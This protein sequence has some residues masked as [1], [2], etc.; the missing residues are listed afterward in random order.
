MRT[1]SVPAP[2]SGETYRPMVNL[3]RASPVPLYHQISSVLQAAIVSGELAP[4]ARI[5]NELA[6]AD[7]LQVSRPTARRALQELVDK[8]LLVRKRGVGTEVAPEIIR[9]PVE[10][11]S[12]HDD[13]AAAGREPRT[14]VLDYEVRPADAETAARL[15]ISPGQDVVHVRRLRYADGEPLALLTNDIRADLAPGREEL[16]HEGLYA[17]LR[18]RGVRL[19]LA[20]QTIGARQ[21][22]AA[23]A[24]VLH[25]PARAAVLTM[26]RVAIADTDTVVE[27]GTHIYRASRYTFQTSLVAR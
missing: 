27:V 24:R 25:E 18:E 22:T 17:A 15:G 5:E 21:A 3:D 26:E 16:E 4:H 1:T 12:L 9:R 19:R 23:E 6:M 11:T 2:T 10:L 7:R 8:G 20:H 14:D 13:L